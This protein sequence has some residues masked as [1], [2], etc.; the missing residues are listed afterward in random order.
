M[1]CVH[2]W[3]HFRLER[4]W[5]RVPKWDMLSAI[6]DPYDPSYALVAVQYYYSSSHPRRGSAHNK[7]KDHIGCVQAL[8]GHLSIT[9]VLCCQEGWKVPALSARLAATQHGYYMHHVTS[10]FHWTPC[11]IICGLC[12]IWYDGLVLGIWS[13]CASWGIAV[14]LLEGLIG[15][16]EYNDYHNCIQ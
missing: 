11:R 10:A 16:S 9:L 6:W 8:N 15:C 12:S 5:V 3:T 7:G 4:L 2:A 1:A 14:L 13:A